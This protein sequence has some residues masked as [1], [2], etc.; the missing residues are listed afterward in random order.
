MSIQFLTDLEVLKLRQDVIRA[1]EGL[2]DYYLGTASGVKGTEPRLGVPEV[3]H[4]VQ[5][6]FNSVGQASGFISL[7]TDFTKLKQGE[8]LPEGYE[9]HRASKATYWDKDGIL[10]E[11]DIDEPRFDYDPLTG[12]ALGLLAESQVTNL[13]SW[14]GDAS[15]WSFAGGTKI[16]GQLD[17]SGGNTAVLFQGPGQTTRTQNA[18]SVTSGPHTATLVVKYHS[19]PEGKAFFIRNSTTKEAFRAITVNLVTG[20]ASHPEEMLVEPLPNGFW[21]LIWSARPDDVITEGDELLIYTGSGM[22]AVKEDF[23]IILDYAQLE[24]G[25]KATSYIP[26]EDTQVTRAGDFFTLPVGDWYRTDMGTLVVTSATPLGE[27]VAKLGDVEIYSDSN[28]AKEYKATYNT[29]NNATELEL[30][31]GTFKSIQYYN[32]VLP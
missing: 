2:R 5:E 9:F 21:K 13:I 16:E 20:E 14:S 25:T 22:A 7:S 18:I 4:R 28:E 10:R 29:T 31:V 8:P 19:G 17:S 23:A 1:K 12:E 30:G 26:T 32:S 27:L 15:K 11:A 3:D 6:L 24:A